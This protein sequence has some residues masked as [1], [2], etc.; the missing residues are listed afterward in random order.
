MSMTQAIVAPTSEAN[1]RAILRWLMREFIEQF[2][3][4]AGFHH[5]RDIIRRAVRDGECRSLL[6]GRRCIG[7]SVYTLCPPRATIDILEIHPGFRERGHGKF[8]ASS[9]ISLLISKGADSIK[10]ECSPASSQ[11]FW[12]P[13]GFVDSD[14]LS[15]SS[16]QP[17]L[18]LRV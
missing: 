15:G 17:Q 6:L 4:Q 18:V 7:F 8:L 16:R 13:L 1:L 12:R 10:V 9:I 14:G 5:N 2:D 11:G 3:G